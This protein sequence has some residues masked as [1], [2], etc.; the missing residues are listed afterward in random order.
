LIYTIYET[1]KEID[2]SSCIGHYSWK[3]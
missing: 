1:L 3:Y 2:I